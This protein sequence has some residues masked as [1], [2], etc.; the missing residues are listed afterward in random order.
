MCSPSPVGTRACVVVVRAAQAG[1]TRP[2]CSAGSRW[3]RFT[4]TEEDERAFVQVSSTPRGTLEVRVGGELRTE[5]TM[6]N[7][8]LTTAGYVARGLQ[9]AS[10]PSPLDDQMSHPV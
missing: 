8:T 7:Y 5:L 10:F 1:R 3:H 9:R 4:F 6:P 2:A